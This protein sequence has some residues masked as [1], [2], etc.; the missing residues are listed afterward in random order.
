MTDIK[1]LN[2]QEITQLLRDMGEPAFRGKQV[3]TWLHRGVTS[4]AE[5]TGLFSIS[6]AFLPVAIL[7][8]LLAD[9]VIRFFV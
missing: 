2:R 9:V 3:F 5:M 8:M 6:A 7:Q 1:S 4:F